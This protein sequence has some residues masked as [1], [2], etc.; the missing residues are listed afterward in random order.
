[1]RLTCVEESINTTHTVVEVRK[2]MPWAV[3]KVRTATQCLHDVYL[4]DAVRRSVPWL[5]AVLAGDI[6]TV[7]DGKFKRKLMS[8]DVLEWGEQQ[9]PPWLPHNIISTSPTERDPTGGWTYIY[10]YSAPEASRSKKRAR[11][12][13]PDEGEVVAVSATG[14]AE[15]SQSDG[16]ASISSTT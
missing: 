15:T 8:I 7:G 6:R 9:Q 12:Q 14:S 5:A 1:M 13:H 2:T 4:T 3:L 16:R 10:L 11:Q